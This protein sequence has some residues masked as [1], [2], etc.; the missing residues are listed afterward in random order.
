MI[1]PNPMVN[2]HKSGGCLSCGK[3]EGLGRRKY[4]SVTCRQQLRYQL[5]V[6]TGLLKALNTRYATFYFTD[7]LLVLDI[8]PY[9][10]SGIFS[11][12][13]PRESGKKPSEDFSQMSNVLGNRWWQ[14]KKRTRRSYLASRLVLEKADRKN[15]APGAL[16][17]QDIRIP[18]LKGNGRSLVHLQLSRADLDRPE[19]KKVIKSAFRRQARKHHPDFGGGGGAFRRI[20]QAYEDLMTWAEEPTFTR[21]SGFPDKWFY[22]GEKNRWVQPAPRRTP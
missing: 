5:N 22:D 12:L 8:L 3:T 10:E 9:N 4:C 15:D 16:K 18:T 20:Y 2:P 14:E 19:L 6:R 13:Y 17:P 1:D 21:R 11:F 7:S